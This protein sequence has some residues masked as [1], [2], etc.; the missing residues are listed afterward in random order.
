MSLIDAYLW[1]SNVSR[2]DI[3]FISSQL[4]RFVSN[5]GY[6]HYRVA[7]RVLIYLQGSANRGLDLKPNVNLP[8]RGFVDA[9]WSTKFSVSGAII[10]YMGVPMHW[11]SRSHRSVSMSSIVKY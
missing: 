6:I 10:D 4:A 5:P 3:C 8:L 2:Q 9:N 7:L 11:L 1:L